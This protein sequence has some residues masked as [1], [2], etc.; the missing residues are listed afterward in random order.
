MKYSY[1]PYNKFD[2]KEQWIRLSQGCPNNCPFCYEPTEYEVYEIP[3]LVRNVVKIMDM[4]LLCKPEALE[5][6][7]ELGRRKVNNKVIQYEFICGIDW[8]VLTPELAVAMRQSR[9]KTIRMAWDFGFHLQKNIKA[10][11]KTLLAAGYKPH[12]ITVF[13]VCNWLTPYEENCMKLDLCKVWGTKVADCWFDNQISPNIEPV[14]WTEEQ[15]K[16]F[17]KACRKHNQMV[18]FGIDPEYKRTKLKD[19]FKV[20]K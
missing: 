15:I 13:M 16:T 10:T 11:V 5:I 9:F 1:G 3:E 4:N 12:D 7:Q 8:R 20:V 19:P 6:I 14:H 17:R 18:R 2:E